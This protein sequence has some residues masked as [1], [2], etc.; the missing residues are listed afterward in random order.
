MHLDV[1]TSSV[2]LSFNEQQ[3]LIKDSINK[4]RTWLDQTRDYREKALESRQLFLEN[5]PEGQQFTTPDA[6]DESRSNVR[7]PII[8]QVVDSTLAQQHLGT[9][10][11]D[12][13]FFKAVPGNEISNKKQLAYEESINKRMER[14]DFLHKSKMDR[15][16]A[17]LDGCSMVHHPYVRKTRR[18]PEYVTKSLLGIPFSTKKVYKER[19]I[20]EATDFV[21]MSLEDW[22]I[23]PCATSLE[24]TNVITREWVDV[25]YVKQQDEFINT[26]DLLT[27]KQARSSTDDGDSRALENRRLM[28]F[29]LDL[30]EQEKAM[31]E[32]YVCL[33]YEWGD[34]YIEDKHYKDHVLI[35][36]NDADVHY[37]APNP[38]DHGYKPFSIHSYLPLPGTLMGKSITRDVIPLAHAYDALINSAIDIINNSASPIWTYLVSD[39]SLREYFKEGRVTMRP[40]LTIPIQSHDSLQSF[41]TDLN[42]LGV[43]AQMM[44]KVKEEIRETTGGVPYAT[45]GI[46]DLDAERTATEVNTLASGTSTRYQDIIQNY[47][48]A[49]LKPYMWMWFENDRQ[50]ISEAIQVDDEVL[51]PL[52][53][54][55]MD[56]EFDILGSKTMA[57]QQREVQG[58]MAI[59][60]MLPQLL[61]LGT[62]TIKADQVEIDLASM[63]KQV[64]RGQGARDIDEYI[65]TIVTQEEAQGSPLEEF[66]NGYQPTN[67]AGQAFD[68]GAIA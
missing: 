62:F 20:L 45:G 50:F 34:F 35:Y 52:D 33:F 16:N 6:A 54:R 13:K 9:F 42:N 64:G 17:M 23:D 44:Q 25:Q 39:A 11:T 8:A 57:S 67:P 15:M 40:G 32:H 43:I 31:A 55:Q 28:G 10:P 4:R 61:Q 56:Y 60:N 66:I 48:G 1:F 24:D 51:T 12:E 7:M 19:V 2:D 53:I 65:K 59:V 18:R 27:Y 37:F 30:T 41:Q 58:L 3:E 26:E 5:R 14:L 47:E 49:K 46:G 22:W 21:P 63:L 38:F 29:D 68:L 36:S